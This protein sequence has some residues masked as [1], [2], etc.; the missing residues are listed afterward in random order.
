MTVLLVNGPRGTGSI[1]MEQ[2]CKLPVYDI[3]LPAIRARRALEEQTRNA[4]WERTE[5]DWR[6]AERIRSWRS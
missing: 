6:R 5:R 4:K 3:M 1:E 2:P